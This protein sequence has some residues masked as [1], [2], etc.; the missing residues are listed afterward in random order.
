MA[1]L[2][3]EQIDGGGPFTAELS[4]EEFQQLQLK[5]GEEIFVE[6]KNVKIFPDDFSI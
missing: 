6:L 1:T 5:T 2:E 4:K 3:L